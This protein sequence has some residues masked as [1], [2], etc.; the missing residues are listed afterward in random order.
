M[1]ASWRERFAELHP[2]RFFGDTL[3]AADKV[4]AEYRQ[5]R[6]AAGLGVDW[7]AY[8]TLVLGALVLVAL[9]YAGGTNTA[10]E[11]IS[12]LAE[13]DPE[14]AQIWNSDK[15]R[16]WYGKMWW[17]AWRFGGYFLVPALFTKFIL[18]ENVIDHGLST[19]GFREHAWIYGVALSVVLVLVFGVSFLESFQNKYPMYRY[20]GSSWSDFLAWEAVYAVQF[21]SL[22]FFFRGHWMKVLER[23]M[24]GAAIAAMMVPYCMIHFG[25][26]WPETVGAIAAGLVLGTLALRSRSIWAGFLVHVS[27]AVAMDIAA[28]LQTSGLPEH[29]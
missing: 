15:A 26:P 10:Y 11:L 3:R 20:A 17:G 29:W 23:S 14:W 18:K 28:L 24:G 9:Q 16:A 27:V 22:E 7:R 1:S 8:A 6:E 25:K 19:K 2:A 21:F 13:D 12:T 5:K 4:A